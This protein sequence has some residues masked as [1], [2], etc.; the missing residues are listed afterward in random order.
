MKPLLLLDI[1][2]VLCPFGG[3][4]DD[5]FEPI[6]GHEFARIDRRHTDWLRE[7]SDLYKPAWASFWEEDANRVIGPAHG[8]DPFPH[9]EF[10]KYF[11]EGNPT[12]ENFEK[13]IAKTGQTPKLPAVQEYVKD[14]PLAWVED[15]LFEDAYKWAFERNKTIPT[16]LIHTD[17]RFGLDETGMHDL[18]VFGYIFK[19]S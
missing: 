7:L 18:R 10:T 13:L 9:I 11:V 4:N 5:S 17:P 16:R 1:D 8:L 2:G 6:I 3:D 12:L 15:D 19:N 14:Q